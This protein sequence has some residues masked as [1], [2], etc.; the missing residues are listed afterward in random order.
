MR[1]VFLSISGQVDLRKRY[2]QFSESFVVDRIFES[3]SSQSWIYRSD[4]TFIPLI[5]SIG[6]LHSNLRNSELN[7][8]T[9]FNAEHRFIGNITKS[10]ECLRVSDNTNRDL[11]SI[12]NLNVSRGQSQIVKLSYPSA[13]NGRLLSFRNMFRFNV[14][15]KLRL[16]EDH[17]VDRRARV[18]AKINRCDM[19][20][21]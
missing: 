8:L 21:R 15:F 9:R 7:S 19:H 20:F 12:L 6:F 11:N 3:S 10:N 14:E 1:C 4:S 5:N 17:I 2:F 18:E 16:A 13:T